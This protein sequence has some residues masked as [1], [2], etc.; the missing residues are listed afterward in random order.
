MGKVIILGHGGFRQTDEE[1]L[2]PPNTELT[3]YSDAGSDLELPAKEVDGVLEFDYEAVKNAYE[4]LNPQN[5][6]IAG[7]ITYNFHLQPADEFERNVARNL[8]WGGEL[9]TPDSG[10]MHLCTGNADT[11]PTPALRAAMNAY[12][13]SGGA[14]GEDVPDNRWNHDCEGI[15]GKYA[16][17]DI[18]WISCTG[19][20]GDPSLLTPEM[21]DATKG[22]GA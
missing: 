22:P 8:N 10:E 19:W 18:H 13:Q 20:R 21:R 12:V 11:C 6:L 9:V 16:T 3:F 5:V 15:L 17:N 14:E 4:G 1:R 2:V 7:G